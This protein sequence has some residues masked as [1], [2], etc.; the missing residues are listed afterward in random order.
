MAR[1]QVEKFD[2]SE[3]DPGTIAEMREEGRGLAGMPSNFGD[4]Y[5]DGGGGVDPY[6]G[7]MQGMKEIGEHSYASYYS[8]LG[9]ARLDTDDKIA[10]ADAM[11]ELATIQMD[12]PCNNRLDQLKRY[13][14]QLARALWHCGLDDMD[15]EDPNAMSL[16]EFALM[17]PLPEILPDESNRK[18]TAAWKDIEQ[19]VKSI[20]DMQDTIRVDRANGM[21]FDV[22]ALKRLYY[23]YGEDANPIILANKDLSP[24]TFLKRIVEFC[25]VSNAGNRP[26]HMQA[27]MAK[28]IV[29]PDTKVKMGLRERFGRRR[30]RDDRDDDEEMD[31]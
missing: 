5:E 27:L 3:H 17:L 29:L 1:G 4:S 26:T 2:P 14:M 12:A 7:W 22:G 6:A 24:P 18:L 19:L 8:F 16:D 25:S 30:R 28:G 20:T 21:F 9:D 15:D 13:R 31:T 23:E 10:Y 11:M